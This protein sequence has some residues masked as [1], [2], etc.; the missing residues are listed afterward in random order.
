MTERPQS[1][2]VREVARA[3][4]ARLRGAGHRALWA[5]GCVRDLLLGRPFKDVDIATSARPEQV[6]TLFPDTKAVGRAF[7]VILVMERGF[8]F[9]VATF[10]TDGTYR[11]G[12]HPE[13]VAFSDEQADARRR[14]FTINAL[15]F[16]PFT[17]ETLDYVGGCADLAVRRIRCVGVAADRF[18][19]DHLRLLRAARFASVLEFEIEPDTFSAMRACASQLRGISAERVRIELTRLLTE[20]PHPGHGL[21]LLLDSAL[22]NEVL[23]EVAALAGVEQ[24]DQFHPEGDVF[25]HTCLALEAMGPSP[26][27][28]LAWAILLHDIAK[29][30]TVRRMITREGRERMGFPDHPVRGAEMAGAILGRLKFSN[31]QTEM[32]VNSIREHAKFHEVPH[33]K[34]STRMT[35]AASPWMDVLLELHR[36]DRVSGNRALDS[37]NIVKEARRKVMEASGLPHPLVKGGDLLKRGMAAGPRLGQLIREIY[38]LQLEHPDWPREKLLKHVEEQISRPTGM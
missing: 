28:E 27:P 2:D 24:P 31:A 10:R 4:T 32:I 16:D 15:F 22:L 25:R 9:E 1:E 34:N 3:V 18:C 11:D 8:P 17:N 35:W 14:D 6:Q 29:P 38:A 20:S 19:E 5:G 13:S 7:G 21:K 12:R 26:S 30:V 23:P 37:W 33:M 36:C